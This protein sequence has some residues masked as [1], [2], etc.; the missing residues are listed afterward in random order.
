[1]NNLIMI[2]VGIAIWQFVVAMVVFS[3]DDE[4]KVFTIGIGIVGWIIYWIVTTFVKVTKIYSKE[5]CAKRIVKSAK[6]ELKKKNKN[7]KKWYKKFGKYSNSAWN[8]VRTENA[9][10]LQE[11]KNSG[12]NYNESK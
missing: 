4:E 1:M 9:E 2:L 5:N 8:I 3:T 12:F 6:K 10:I 7:W 11:M